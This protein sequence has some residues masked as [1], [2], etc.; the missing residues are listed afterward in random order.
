MENKGKVIRVKVYLAKVEKRR[1][2]EKGGIDQELGKAGNGRTGSDLKKNI[3]RPTLS[4]NIPSQSSP[5]MKKIK[6]MNEKDSKKKLIA[7]KLCPKKVLHENKE[8]RNSKSNLIKIE[9]F[10]SPVKT[11]VTNENFSS[12]V[13]IPANLVKSSRRLALNSILLTTSKLNVH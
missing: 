9:K 4:L 10:S 3:H 6:K 12:P 1:E 8:N 7:R 2:V 5:R 13:E 11:L